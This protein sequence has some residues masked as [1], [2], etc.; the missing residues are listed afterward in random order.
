MRF[1]NGIILQ[2][3]YVI[4]IMIFMKIA[5]SVSFLQDNLLPSLGAAVGSL[6]LSW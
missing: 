2:T 6:V 4:M 5:F 1:I 3:V